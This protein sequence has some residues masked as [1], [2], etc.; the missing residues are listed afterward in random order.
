MFTPDEGKS[1]ARHPL[2]RRSENYART[3]V[4]ANLHAARRLQIALPHGR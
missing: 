3:A 1:G 4:R 2:A